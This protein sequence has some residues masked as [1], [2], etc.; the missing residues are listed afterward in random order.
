MKQK[1]LIKCLK[2]AL[3][4]VLF[5][6]L[7][8]YTQAQVNVTLTLRSNGLTGSYYTGSVSSAGVKND[9]NMITINSSAN[10][11]WARYDLSYLPAG[12]TIISANVVF[13]TY[14]TTLS[15]ATNNIYGFTGDPN[16][17]TGA[18]LYT[19]CG[20]GTSF[21][22]TSWAA[23]T[24]LT[25]ALNGTGVTFL[26]T[27]L[28]GFVNFGFVRGSTN[29]YNIY[30]YPAR[31]VNSDPKLVIV[32]SI[33]SAIPT[34]PVTISATNILTT[35]ATL[36]GAVTAGSLHPDSI[37]LS[38]IVVGT[39]ANP[40]VGGIGVIDS[41][42]RPTVSSGT[43]NVNIDGLTLGTLYHY[44]AYAIDSGVVYYGGDSTFTT[45]SGAL[46]PSLTT[47]AA[48]S[49]NATDATAGGN[50][51]SNGGSPV[52][53]SGIVYSLATNP[54]LGGFGVIDSTTNPLVLSGSFSKTLGG[55]TNTTKYYFRAYATNSAGTGYGA[56]DSFTTAPVVTTL[57]YAQNFD[58]V[59]TTGWS[60]TATG[61]A[62]PW[63]L[64]TPAKA[65]ITA[66]YS[67]PNSW[68]TGTTA[69][70]PN[71]A[72][73]A[74]VSPQLDFTSQ[75][76]DP[77]IRFR[78]NFAGES[79]WDGGVLEVSVNGGTT[80][81][82]LDNT[83][84][85]GATFNTA[86]STGWYNG[87]ANALGGN[88]W[89]NLS[90]AYTGHTGGWIQSQT[91]LT[92]T[93]GQANVKVRFRFASDASF[94]TPPD[95]WAVDNIE[96]FPPTAPTVTTGSFSNLTTSSVTL[97]GSITGNGGAAVTASG[98]VVGTSANPL[99]AG[100]GVI[101]S[102]TNP[103]AT[104]GSIS[105]NF[106]GLS[107]ATTYYYRTYAVNAIGTS[108]GPDST[109]TTNS[110][111]TVANITRIAASN[112]AAYVTTVGGNISSNGG[113]TVLTSGVV[114]ST[115]PNPALAGVG[116]VDSTTNPVVAIGSFSFT[117]GGLTPN[118]KYY[119]RA[120]A[121]NGVG[122]AYSTQDSFTTAPVIST[123]PYSQNFDGVG[124]TGWGSVATGGAN[125]WVLGTPAKAQITAAYSSPNSWVTGTTAAYPNS[126]NAALVSPQLDFTSQTADPIIRFR[127]NFAGESGWDGGILEV[128]LNGG[129][130]WNKLDNNLGTGGTFNTANSTGW[131]NGNAN[132]LG[133]NAWQNV[134]TAYTGHSG[135]WIQ[136]ATAITGAAGQGN[137]KVRFRFASDASFNTPPDGWAVDNIEI[138]PPSAPTVTTGVSSNITTS[139]VTLG[140]GVTGNGGSTITAS[141]IVIGTSANPLRAGIGVIDSATNPLVTTGTFTL[142]VTGL[143]TATTYYYRTYAVNAVGTSYGPDSTFTTNSAA[144]V[145]NVLRIAAS[146]VMDTFATV[147]GNITSNGGS[148]V[149]ASGIVYS[150]TPN[151]ALA[152][153]G[154]VDSTTNPL[155]GSGT[156]SFTLAG[157]T[158]STKYYYRAYATNA[159]GTAYSVE[160]SFTTAP[161]VS[162]L[163]YS[164]NFDATGV[165]T[166]WNGVSTGG[167]NPWVL[168]T[169][170][171][172]Q[173]LAAYS[174]TKAWVTA[175]TGAYPDG[176]NA[177]VVSPRLD[178][179]SVTVDP[180]IR[181]RNNFNSESGW[182]GGIL[183][184]STNGGTTWTKLDNVT[185]TGATFNTANSSGWYNGTANAHG[186]TA[187]QNT[188]TAYTGHSNGWIQSQTSLTGAA[189]Q[190][191]VKVRFRFASDASFT[192]PDG[193][194]ID[195]IEIF[196]PT[197]PVV[198]TGTKTNITT[199]NVTLAGNIVSNGNASVTASGV[200]VS[201]TPTPVRGGLGVTDSTTN[202]LVNN[203]AFSLNLTG[204]SAATTYYYRAYAVNAVG[205]SYGADST[206]TTNSSAVAPTVVATTATGFTATT[207]TIG[208]NITSNGGS[209]VTASG[210]VYSTTPNPVISGG[211]VVDST[212]NPVV[213]N[214]T[215]SFN[216]AG[217]TANT[218]YYYRAY[219]INVVGT[220]YSANDSF[221][222][223]PII[224]TLPYTQN[225]DGVGNTGWSSAANG[226]VNPWV[227]G[228]PAK[229]QITG[230]HSGA[231][232]WVTGITGAYPDG[233][234]AS[235][236][237]PQF[238]MTSV[239]SDPVISF[240]HNF[241]SESG[242][243]GGILEVSTNGGTSWTQLDNNAG[244]GGNFITAGSA[245]WYNGNANSI[246]MAWQ[247]TSTAYTGQASG[248]IQT[249][250]RLTGVAGQANVRIRFRFASDASFTT[251]DGWSIDDIN[252]YSVFA[253][254]TQA[255]AVGGTNVSND[256]LTVS[257]T[258]GNGAE[259]MVVA[260][261]TTSAPIAPQDYKMYGS[262]RNFGTGDSTGLGNY[263]VYKG[264]GNTVNVKAL[265]LA[266]NYTFTVY[267]MNG[268]W[269]HTRFATP[270]AT[271]SATTLPVT[272]LSFDGAA[273]GKD[274]V[275]AW[276][277]ANELNNSGFDLER[278]IN[279]TSFE[280]V[281]F[282]KGKG[283]TNMVSN[284]H[285]V[286]ANAL[287]ASAVWYYRLKQIDFDGSI[288][289][290]NTIKVTGK[291]L[292]AGL[293][294]F[295][296]PFIEGLNIELNLPA[297]E[298]VSVIIT[299]IQGKVVA[300]RNVNAS[301]GLNTIGFADLNTLNEGV[302]F[303]KTSYS[304][305]SSVTK[306]VKIK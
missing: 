227:L 304:G 144:T 210:V 20:S 294:V 198:T 164:Q 250:T 141:G 225:F 111:A 196:V 219:A 40:T 77:I 83:L 95:G 47:T 282:V 37:S 229:T 174:G 165:A 204:L 139:S 36:R 22:A 100:V 172:T 200:V 4:L 103:L 230:A 9:G 93:A 156:Y 23:N 21:N 281:T 257:W 265:A 42:S 38:G 72:N 143:A 237:S 149:L 236:V 68:V 272:L 253:P 32:Y 112:V 63:V 234:N 138:F 277:T 58:G 66:A 248:W 127:H 213:A 268:T 260:R 271:T 195:N 24:V 101:D 285:F 129:T 185:G 124:V 131:Y 179:S 163:P 119:Y 43:F 87:N 162:V 10:R 211:G 183:E 223:D 301:K 6:V 146:N 280:K 67:S 105:L 258:N 73:G 306:V 102:A 154:V 125:P 180:V 226:G 49:V 132:S 116:V 300:E 45:A 5:S 15:G 51:S 128:S 121:I 106:A 3:F 184:I 205:T 107:T 75:T 17:M 249:Q 29:T 244:T 135:G 70:Y 41:V 224:S 167:N 74:L 79:G 192:T 207:A 136:S 98:I 293:S 142:N 292:A 133:G 76:V 264:T 217:L 158:H 239:T 246:G 284:Y 80:W 276:S 273:D 176:A 279:G 145:A 110:A 266:T 11:G 188:S 190:G 202:P 216:V 240:W 187:W 122:T 153:V 241:N 263:I 166:G 16:S 85:T 31:D 212:T 256:S 175:A 134:S 228:T 88:A 288:T 94:N 126:A 113:S 48:S 302:Y 130:T 19:A 114:Y 64:G 28:G 12:A 221:T 173:I 278:S 186:G 140:G 298:Q 117:L 262:N 147:G 27:N 255:S 30:G 297:A 209:A 35:T 81:T 287:S 305:V 267:E 118:T 97:G 148:A 303:V 161:V 44:R 299:D 69:A 215:Y 182:D 178:L 120:Y 283:T 62:N 26:Q 290:S 2:P 86:N 171:K 296:N 109:F 191:N 61:G 238:N 82:K 214:G 60:T 34:T 71:A 52:L 220:A 206:F 89:Q 269:M 14:S 151:P 53:T 201:A 231:K 115:T 181:F 46:P 233:S 104:A 252:I 189:G 7:A 54:T 96:I 108:Y 13:T 270:G 222:T 275:L 235:V 274:V 39:S 99:R 197:A 84:G 193:W 92:G 247:N 291:V 251:P 155:V 8:Q 160:D 137:V 123:F 177:A 59:G 56:L 65:Q 286:D 150:T 50:I 55:L 218:K 245:N 289:Y 168:G 295:P 199:S 170:A 208:G 91:A 232:A 169:P 90:T 242:W 259:R 57:P 18:A 157:L 78:H 261:R 1:L 152:G 243:D 159:V 194:A 33:P 254:T 203:G 25:K